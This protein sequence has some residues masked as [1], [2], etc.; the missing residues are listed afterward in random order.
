MFKVGIP[1][2]FQAKL[3]PGRRPFCH[4]DATPE[5]YWITSH[6]TCHV[7]DSWGCIFI[8]CL[9][10]YWINNLFFCLFR[11][12][13]MWG[14]AF[15]FYRGR[16]QKGDTYLWGVEWEY[17]LEHDSITYLILWELTC[18]C[19]G[20][21]FYCQDIMA[22]YFRMK[23][24]PTLWIPGTDHAGIATQVSKLSLW[25]IVV[26]WYGLDN[27]NINLILAY[28]CFCIFTCY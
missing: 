25:V 17:F 12:H 13:L 18:S 26:Y 7:C 27:S 15:P 9:P 4:S 2:V 21:N 6:G 22:R 20:I 16:E 3:W 5:C 24:R 19:I 28:F 11:F 14:V 23:G 8:C 10:F 1:G